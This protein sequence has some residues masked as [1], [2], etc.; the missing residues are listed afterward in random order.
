MSRLVHLVV[1][2]PLTVFIALDSRCFVS[3][4]LGAPGQ[5]VSV[6]ERRGPS[7]RHRSQSHEDV[8]TWARLSGWVRGL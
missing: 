3:G 6:A 7:S 4:P 8:R 1:A 2:L 5:F